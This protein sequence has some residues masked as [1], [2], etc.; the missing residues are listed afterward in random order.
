MLTLRIWKLVV[1]GVVLSVFAAESRADDKADRERK[2]KAALA[3][4]GAKGPA[5]VAQP[6]P[7]KAAEAAVKAAVEAT[8]KAAIAICRACGVSCECG[9]GNCPANCPTPKAQPATQLWLVNGRIVELPVG[10]MPGNCP[11]G[12]CPAPGR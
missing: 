2:A 6:I 12:M 9:G 4:A 11:T 7:T 10:V 1:V 5:I 8:V 3:L